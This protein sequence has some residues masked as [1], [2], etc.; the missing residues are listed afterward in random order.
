MVGKKCRLSC[1]E[2]ALLC[3]WVVHYYALSVFSVKNPADKS[4]C[5]AMATYVRLSGGGSF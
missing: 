1:L 3:V 4:P 2:R 5:V